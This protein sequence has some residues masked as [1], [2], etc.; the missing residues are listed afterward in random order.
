MTSS[1]SSAR[2]RHRERR[3]RDGGRAAGRKRS[4]R[5]HTIAVHAKQVCVRDV[6]L[7]IV[8][9]HKLTRS[10]TAELVTKTRDHR[11]WKPPQEA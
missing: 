2:H 4:R 3:Q 10:C 11:F 9:D 1:F 7:V 5:S 6:T 8:D